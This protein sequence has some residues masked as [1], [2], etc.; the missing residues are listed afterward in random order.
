LE[1]NEE[2]NLGQ[3]QNKNDQVVL[4]KQLAQVSKVC[5]QRWPFLCDLYCCHVAL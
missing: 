1:E 5:L 3:A 4:G 2:G